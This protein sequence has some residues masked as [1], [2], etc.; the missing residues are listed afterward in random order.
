MKMRP[1]RI[2]NQ[3]FISRESFDPFTT[4]AVAPLERPMPEKRLR[5]LSRRGKE[6]L[7]CSAAPRRM[8]NMPF[9]GIPKTCF[10]PTFHFRPLSAAT[11]FSF[12]CGFQVKP[13]YISFVFFDFWQLPVWCQGNW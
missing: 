9:S 13:I 12:S 2:A 5:E 4:G 10:R 11:F 8:Q 3:D 1:G 7:F 6:P